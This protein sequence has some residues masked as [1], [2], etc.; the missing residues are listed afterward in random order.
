MIIIEVVRSFKYLGTVFN[1]TNYDR[2]E[3]SARIPATNRA[4]CSLQT[5]FRSKQTHRNKKIRPYTNVIEYF[6]IE[7]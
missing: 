2:G 6:V 3:I 5:M 1:N 4:Y 7:D